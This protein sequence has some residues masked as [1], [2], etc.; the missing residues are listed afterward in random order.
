MTKDNEWGNIELPG[1]S[2]EELFAKNWNL[3]ASL[4]EYWNKLTLKERQEFGQRITE[5][6]LTIT[7]QQAQEIWNRVW[8]PDRSLDLYKKLAKE[9]DVAYNA[10][11][12]IALGDHPLSP[13]TKEQWVEI[14][15]DWHNKYGYTKNIYIVRSPGNDLLDFYDQQNLLRG[16]KTSKLSPSEIFD[17]RF[18]RCKD[19]QYTKQLLLSK[20]IKVDPNM[21]NGYAND[22]MK[23]LV[24][25]PHQEW[26]FDSLVEM[27]EWLHTKMN[28]SFKG[29]GQLAEKY[30]KSKMLW[31][32]RGYGLNG[33]SFIKIE[34]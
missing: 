16:S 9:Y 31:M 7:Q 5:A 33:W 13:V 14:H 29:G 3:V 27:S 34:K 26:Q 1:L 11:F 2:D 20:G 24:N 22:I 6:K 12:M 25:E 30:I 10:V 8:G 19:T 28:K 32:D 18:N 21:I 17:I 23:W 4:R 15:N